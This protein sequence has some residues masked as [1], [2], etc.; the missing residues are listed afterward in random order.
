M[1]LEDALQLS[2]GDYV[3]SKY[4]GVKPIRR[5][6]TKVWVSADRQHV[7]LRIASFAGGA[8]WIG[9]Q[10]WELWPDGQ[11][12]LMGKVVPPASAQQPK[13]NAQ[14]GLGVSK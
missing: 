8:D 13:H 5:R 3:W 7:R 14:L 9:A 11:D 10:L 4:D 6:V 1:T 2:E 12:T